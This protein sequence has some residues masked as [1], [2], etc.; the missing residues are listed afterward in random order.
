M[1]DCLSDNVLVALVEGTVSETEMQRIAEH[2][3]QCA[4]CRMLTA[5][6]AIS[7]FRDSTRD[8]VA[9]SGYQSRETTDSDWSPPSQF[10]EYRL[11]GFLGRGQMG[12]VY[13]GVDTALDR[14]VA[15]KFLSAQA[16]DSH[17]V[18]R[19]RNES[20]AIARLQHPHVVSVYRAGEVDG[21]PYLVSEFVPGRSLD[22]VRLPIP[23][24]LLLSYAI[25]LASALAA[26]HAQ[27]ILHRDIK[28]ANAM[29][30][31]A[32]AIK[33]L[34]FGLAKLRWAGEGTDRSEL[35]PLDACVAAQDPMLTRTGMLLGTPRYMAAELWRG[36]GATPQSDVYSLGALL[37]EL[38]CGEPPFPQSPL[39][40]LILASSQQEPTPLINRCPK[41]DQQLAAIIH[42]C[43]AKSPSD[44]FLDGSALLGA[45][46]ACTEAARSRATLRRQLSL[47]IAGAVAALLAGGLTYYPKLAHRLRIGRQARI[48]GRTT[49]PLGMRVI[50]GGSFV[51]GS[52]ESEIE[53]SANLCRSVLAHASEQNR[54]NACGSM[55]REG[56]A[57]EVEVSTFLLDQYEVTNEA[58]VSWL[59]ALPGLSM[60]W[61]RLVSQNNTFLVDLQ[62]PESG[63]YN[64]PLV[65]LINGNPSRL[66]F[67]VREGWEHR[68][69]VLVT[70]DA[71][72]R[73]CRS[74]H[75]RLPTETEWEYA[76]RGTARRVF[77]WGATYPNCQ[78]VV[79]GRAAGWECDHLPATPMP[80]GSA[81][82][83]R[84][85]AGVADM[86]GNVMEW[87]ADAYLP[88]YPACSLPCIDPIVSPPKDSDS[89]TLR[90]VRGSSYNEPSSFGFGVRRSRW[91]PTDP[92]PNLGFRCAKTVERW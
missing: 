8:E 74:L 35:S 31:N 46:T 23:S 28:P 53:S 1:A 60:R 76:A 50:Q 30:T 58:F 61:G 57:F 59:N 55:R 81:Q 10:D 19:F 13:E 70:W 82:Q 71:A 87:V 92:R 38:A 88:E 89:H 41:I 2:L 86:A 33:L 75:K 68:P 85:P 36:Y 4:R 77:P 78:G 20:R 52:P 83:D 18:E 43:L 24:K 56:P 12:E 72:E 17:G 6:M 49:A 32:G 7:C 3:D 21:R 47:A 34:D 66:Q 80:V 37:Y 62:Q 11:L 48:A 51:R 25:Q 63:I 84:T 67:R 14:R 29:L 64:E 26:A 9:G 45:L 39:R 54:E 65:T 16:P 42:R 91:S 44:R 40:A 5:G 22:R 73:H 79:L 15:I 27:G 69:V 90:S